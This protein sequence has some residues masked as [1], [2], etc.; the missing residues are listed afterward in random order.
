MS[1]PGLA[2]V[3]ALLNSNFQSLKGALG[4]NNPTISTDKFSLRRELLRIH[5]DIDGSID[6]FYLLDK[7][8]MIYSI[9]NTKAIDGPAYDGPQARALAINQYNFVEPTN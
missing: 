6:G 1:G 9:G 2:G 5:P 3:L 8:G 4:F 7:F